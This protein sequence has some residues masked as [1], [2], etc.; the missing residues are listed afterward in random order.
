MDTITL[1]MQPT[2]QDHETVFSRLG[3]YETPCNIYSDER[4]LKFDYNYGF[5]I[6]KIYNIFFPK[7]H[8]K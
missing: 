2:P 4:I 7:T 6:F 5:K 8:S 3:W 1:R